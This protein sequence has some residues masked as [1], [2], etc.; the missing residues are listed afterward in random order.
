MAKT[1]HE[2]GILISRLLFYLPHRSRDKILAS[3]HTADDE[4]MPP[5]FTPV[6]HKTFIFFR[7]N[8]NAVD[9]LTPHCLRAF[10]T[11]R[12]PVFKKWGD[13]LLGWQTKLFCK[14]KITLIVSRHR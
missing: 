9:G 6:E 11:L 14:L 7:I 2:T 4:C 12:S 3:F 13:H 10:L 5:E 1:S 8:K